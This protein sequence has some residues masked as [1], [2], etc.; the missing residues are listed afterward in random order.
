M[1][2]WVCF[3][4]CLR[5]RAKCLSTS[6]TDLSLAATTTVSNLHRAVQHFTRLIADSE[7]QT[8]SS[9]YSLLS[10]NSL[11][12]QTVAMLTKLS[13]SLDAARTEVLK[14]Q[15]RLK[16]PTES[17]ITSDGSNSQCQHSRWYSTLFCFHIKTSNLYLHLSR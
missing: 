12:E 11:L 5:E 7:Q 14:R 2:C 9:L 1:A 8:V 10:D 6:V 16:I 17:H 3:S 13:S 15:A 4:E